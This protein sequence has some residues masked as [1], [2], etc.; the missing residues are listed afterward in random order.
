MSLGR[1][2]LVMV[3]EVEVIVPSTCD[4]AKAAVAH[5][6]VLDRGVV[7]GSAQREHHR[8]H[9]G[10]CDGAYEQALSMPPLDPVEAF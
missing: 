2:V 3:L 9:E 1:A 5:G 6:P 4:A 10:C 8:C 7:G